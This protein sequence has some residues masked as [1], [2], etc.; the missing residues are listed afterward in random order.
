MLVS[1][2]I[3]LLRPVAVC[4]RKAIG[5]IAAEP[6]QFRIRRPQRLPSSRAVQNYQLPQTG[7]EVQAL[8]P[9]LC[10]VRGYKSMSRRILDPVNVRSDCL[11]P[12]RPCHCP[13]VG[14][15]AARDH[16]LAGAAS[17]CITFWVRARLSYFPDDDQSRAAGTGFNG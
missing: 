4:S 13:L 17:V 7:V 11:Y 15:A 2:G 3:E 12:C 16:K 14:R 6:L 8:F 9:Q 10:F 5:S 1:P